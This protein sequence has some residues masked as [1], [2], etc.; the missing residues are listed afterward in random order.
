MTDVLRQVRG[1]A[2]EDNMSFKSVKSNKNSN[3]NS[4]SSF[5]SLNN[6]GLRDSVESKNSMKLSQFSRNSP[7]MIGIIK[8]GNTGLSIL[9]G[10]SGDN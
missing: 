3:K 7:D 4:N 2:N 1:F 6:A 8:R 9:S 5:K 10:N